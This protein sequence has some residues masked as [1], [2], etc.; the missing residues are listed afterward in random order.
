M[1]KRKKA[2][3]IFRRGQAEYSRVAKQVSL[4]R[5][6]GSKATMI[7]GPFGLRPGVMV[8]KISDH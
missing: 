1:K 5:G 4:I 2:Q 8:S 7:F 3:W 6:G